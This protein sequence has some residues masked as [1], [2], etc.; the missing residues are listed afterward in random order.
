MTKPLKDRVGFL[1]QTT[2]IAAICS[3]VGL[4]GVTCA[5][6]FSLGKFI[7]IAAAVWAVDAGNEP[8]SLLRHRAYENW[9]DFVL[10]FLLACDPAGFEEA[11]PVISSGPRSW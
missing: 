1:S 8:N 5:G 10:L 4:A 2:S 3:C 6:I 11:R 9:R 7:S